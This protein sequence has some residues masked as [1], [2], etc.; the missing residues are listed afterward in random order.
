MAST[1]GISSIARRLQKRYGEVSLLPREPLALLVGTI[2]SQNTNDANRDRAYKGL[3]DRFGD[4]AGVQEAPEARIAE[5]IRVGGL[6]HQKARVI[7]QV[8]GRIVRERGSLDLSFL[9]TLSLSEAMDWLL[10]LPGVGHK[11]AG[12]VVLFGF[13]MPYFPVDT[14]IRRV[15]RRLG[16]VGEKDDPHE[17]LNA[18][19]PADPAFL[20][21]LHL[22]LIQLGRELCHPRRPECP[23][24]PLQ[25][26]CPSAQP[27]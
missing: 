5:A 14:H 11:T 1:S 13:G 9:G 25:V 3:L 15:T 7:K 17:H 6:H 24:C 22:H 19:L 16:L 8:L 27:L 18:L 20:R 21:R 10:S 4:L 23:R 12:I 26:G 2:L